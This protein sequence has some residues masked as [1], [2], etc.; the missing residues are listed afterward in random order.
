MENESLNFKEIVRA[1]SQLGKIQD[2]DILLEQLL[3]MSRRMAGADAGSIYVRKNAAGGYESLGNSNELLI[4]YAQNDTRQSRLPPGEKQEYSLF[5]LPINKDSVAGCCA[6][7]GELINISDVYNIPAGAPY[8]FNSNFDKLT[9]YKTT[10]SLTFPLTAEDRVLGVI[11]LI[12]KL[13]KNKNVIAFSEEDELVLTNFALSAAA[14]MQKAYI[15]RAMII[16]MIRLAEL[17]D[18]AET[19]NHV[20]RVAQYSVEI[21]DRWA[22]KKNIPHNERTVFRDSLRIGAM[23]HDVGKVAISDR[24]LKKPG[25]FTD[26]EFIAMKEHTLYGA[27]LFHDALS[28]VDN[29]A[30]EIAL[31]HHEN[32]DG[33][34]YPGWVDPETRTGIKTGKNGLPAGQKGE[35]IPL[36]GRIVAVADVYDALRSRRVYKESWKEEAVLDEMR[37]LSGTRFDPEIVDIFFEVLPIIKRATSM[38]S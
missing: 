35:E 25:R 36:S 22:Y 30:M 14:A 4:R 23:L 38:Y 18:P 16:R 27:G 10:S 2:I 12:N 5:S 28:P 32:W 9:G 20:N 19:G 24:I 26:D 3:L 7:T 15:T 31:T 11:Q 17:R 6:Y 8:S 29:V 34:G 13:D 37:T 33:T 21:Y 1:N